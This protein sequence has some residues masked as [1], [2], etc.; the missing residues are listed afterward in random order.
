MSESTGTLSAQRPWPGLDSFTE[1]NRNYFRGRERE[2]E[3][4]LRLV[5]S[6]TLTSLFGQSGLG[7][8]SLLRAGLYPLLRAADFLPVHLRLD[9][10]ETAPELRLQVLS[11]AAAEAAAHGVE[12]PVV[13]PGET[14]WAYFHR[15]GNRWWSGAQPVIPVL[16]F[17][18]FE[19]IF[20]LGRATPERFA[21]CQ[22]LVDEL[23]WLIEGVVPPELAAQF[24]A[25]AQASTDFAF[26]Q[27]AFRVL[28]AFREDFLADFESLRGRIRS[29]FHSRL[30]LT[31]FTPERALEVVEKV[32]GH[33]FAP[34]V[35]PR[36]IE[37]IAGGVSQAGAAAAAA[38]TYG[39]VE[40]ALLSLVCEQLNEQRIAL[41]QATISGKLLDDSRESI[42]TGFYA[43]ATAGLDPQVKVFIEERLVTGSGYRSQIPRVDALRE[44]GVTAEAIETLVRRRLLRVDPGSGIE[45][46][47]LIHD[48][49]TG[50][51]LGE[52]RRRRAQVERAALEL[53]RARIRRRSLVAYAAAAALLLFS[54]LM[55]WLWTDARYARDQAQHARDEA[56]QASFEAT[57][58]TAEARVAQAEAQQQRQQA[59]ME[60]QKREV[61]EKD[62]LAQA[63]IANK[64]AAEAKRSTRRMIAA[65]LARDEAFEVLTGRG[66][67]TDSADIL[68][69]GTAGTSVAALLAASA[70]TL[71]PDRHE[72]VRAVLA[73]RARTGDVSWLSDLDLPP[74]AVALDRYRNRLAVGL[75]DGAIEIRDA[76]SGARLSS[77]ERQHTRAIFSLA[78]S[79]D[80]R[81]LVSGSDDNESR[82][83]DAATG[84]PLGGPRRGHTDSVRSLA[85]SADGNWIVTGGDDSAVML[86]AT[87]SEK[88]LLQFGT[89]RR[90]DAVALAYSPDGK[91]VVTGEGSGTIQFWSAATGEVVGEPIAG[92]RGSV[93]AVAFSPDGRVLATGGEDN[94]ARLWDAATRAPL[95]VLEG[96]GGAVNALAFSPD[97]RQLAS[98]SGDRTIRL[99]EA[100]TGKALR[101]PLTGHTSDVMTLAYSP[102]GQWLVSGSDDRTLRVWSA[103]S[104]EPAGEPLAGHRDTVRS[105]AISPDGTLLASGSD[106]R[107]V[108]L[109]NFA[110]R[111]PS[112][113]PMTGHEDWVRSVAFS[114]DGS[115]L[116]SGSDDGTL[117]LWDVQSGQLIGK[118]WTGHRGYVYAVAFSPDGRRVASASLNDRLRIWDAASGK[119]LV[120]IAEHEGYVRSVA[121]NPNGRTVASA[122]DDGVRL[123]AN[124]GRALAHLSTGPDTA[125][126]FS[127]DGARLVSGS[128][129]GDMYLWDMTAAPYKPLANLRGARSHRYAIVSVAWAENATDVVVS[130]DARGAVKRWS[131]ASG[132]VIDVRAAGPTSLTGA[133]LDANGRSLA[134]VREDKA[135]G[136]WREGETA[137]LIASLSGLQRDVFAVVASTLGNAVFA[138]G[139]DPFVGGWTLGTGRKPAAGAAAPATGMKVAGRVWTMALSPDSTRLATGGDLQPTLV[140]S[141]AERRVLRSFGDREGASVRALAFHPTEPRWLIVGTLRGMV[142]ALD[143]IGQEAART[144]SEGKRFQ[145]LGAVYSVSASPSGR[146]IATAGNGGR[147][148]LWDFRSGEARSELV[149]HQRRSVL[150]VA[151]N[152]KDEAQLVSGGEDGRLTLWNAGTSEATAVLRGHGSEAVTSV[153]FM[154]DGKHIVSA[155][156]DG[157][158]RMWDAA[159]GRALIDPIVTG[160]PAIRSLSVTP[161]GERVIAAGTGGAVR[162]LNL[163]IAAHVETLCRQVGRDIT[164]QEWKRYSEGS[165][166]YRSICASGSPARIRR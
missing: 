144:F 91:V 23:G 64:A 111:K 164:P 155:G 45:R 133:S 47:E 92:H 40:P 154:P 137:P 101:A 4:L 30:R 3:E 6:E 72:S 94:R 157:T 130:V 86:W 10:T 145:R 1:Q 34:G 87:G 79:P 50:V 129:N 61:A 46:V 100:R 48:V 20:S 77:P 76:R 56:Q 115:R 158:V 119:P 14:L 116:L 17:D 59:L 122:A 88:P 58:A 123:W 16:V 65:N 114:R 71:A 110:T 165:A 5:R 43:R 26:D 163:D 66:I 80:G 81:L 149:G 24:A 13:Q 68:A 78:Y 103:A 9:L 38:R 120:Q 109:W 156:T 74:T 25:G 33:L 121:F 2:A 70:A 8:T 131:V 118:R 82:L 128:Q 12:V 139:L 75:A 97:G 7:K 63:D 142:Q 31:R 108:R 135:L 53:E 29:L 141:A 106:D 112:L 11:A 35:A 148:L 60:L 28:F 42:L 152:P 105:V 22:A 96:H 104:G 57:K 107:T 67:A 37:F 146:T 44:P 21:R 138:A 15:R 83:W 113:A 153:A 136:L 102:D 32:G 140:W 162:V 151:F 39:E 84:K 160:I 62:A 41:T 69:S 125:L 49:L 85:F 89:S 98:A 159:T 36:V 147:I 150:A 54:V 73:A 55:G 134:E 124:D 51:V 90:A 18:Q 161:D 126:A 99:W 117:R 143:T 132:E 166:P 27:N 127:A 93:N 52:R 19:E 95:A